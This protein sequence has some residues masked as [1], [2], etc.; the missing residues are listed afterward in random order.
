MSEYD[1]VLKN[2]VLLGEC[3]Y[4]Q[5]F[6]DRN[7]RFDD[8]ESVKTSRLMC[9]KEDIQVGNIIH[10]MNTKYLLGEQDTYD[11]DRKK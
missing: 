8:G 11:W 3:L 4:G 10:T 9:S 6:E 5:I 2:W 1:A 7:G